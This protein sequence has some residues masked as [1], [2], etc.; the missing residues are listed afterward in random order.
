MDFQK[1][2]QN[3]TDILIDEEKFAEISEEKDV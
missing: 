3:L 2:I 1:A